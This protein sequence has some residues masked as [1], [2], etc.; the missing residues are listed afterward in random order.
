MNEIV[1][2]LLSAPCAFCQYNGE[3]FWQA[4]THAETCPFYLVGGL[5]K[6]VEVLR[7]ALVRIFRPVIDGVVKGTKKHG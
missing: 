7:L 3:R 2:K 4:K 5:D 1:H 6:R